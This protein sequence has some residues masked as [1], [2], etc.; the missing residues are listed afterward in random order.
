MNKISDIPTLRDIHDAH[1]RIENYINDTPILTSGTLN[2]SIG[3][4]IFLKCENFQKVGAFKF[5]GACNAIMSLNGSQVKN[6]I[7][8]HSS[9]NHAQA[10]A[11]AA[12]L[13]GIKAYIVMPNDSPKVK[14]NAVKG[15]GAEM[16]FCR[17]IVEERESTMMEIQSK[18]GAVFIHPY[19]NNL[20]IA[21][22]ATATVE[23]L[24][25]QSNLDIIIAPVGGGGLL[26]G[27]ALAAKNLNKNIKVFG[28][29]P[30]MVDDAYRSN[31][32]GKLQKA[33]NNPTIADGL[34]TALSKLTFHIIKNNVDDILLVDEDEI[35]SAMRFI[36]ERFKIIIEPSS[37]V[38]IACIFKY[39]EL[40]KNKNTGVL[41]S[42]G[43][44]DLNQLPWQQ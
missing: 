25:Q 18:T 5:R 3:G 26:S 28:A 32:T 15:Y 43:N 6:G 34:K 41:I 31:K 42:G 19:D 2:E 13:R 10:V 4:Q 12:K 30:R 21:G 35:I 33:T 22:Q 36:W 27:T 39:A 14:I 11:L 38:A 20:I 37:A 23:L 1:I 9:G 7:I 17:P 8:T 40:F 44:V 16:T 29:E 24:N